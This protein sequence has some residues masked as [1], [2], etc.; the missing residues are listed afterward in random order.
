M[1]TWSANWKFLVPTEEIE[2]FKMWADSFGF[3]YYVSGASDY[4]D[5]YTEIVLIAKLRKFKQYK[6]K[7]VVK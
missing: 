4:E 3:D 1:K 2:L 5:G 7:E 6:S